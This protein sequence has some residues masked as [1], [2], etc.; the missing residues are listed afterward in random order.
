MK[1]LKK[2]GILITCSCSHFFDA[3][4]FYNMLANAAHDAK[5]QHQILEKRGAGPDHPVLTGYP[6][7]EY[8]KCVIARVL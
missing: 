7:S 5:R 4:T 6:K 1:I 8:L 2:G 3:P